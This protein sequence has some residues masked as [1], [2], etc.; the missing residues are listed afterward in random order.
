ML[1]Q[2][3]KFVEVHTNWCA[4]YLI[5][6]IFPYPSTSKFLFLYSCHITFQCVKCITYFW[7]FY[8]KYPP[9]SSFWDSMALTWQ[10]LSFVSIIFQLESLYRDGFLNKFNGNILLVSAYLHRT[11]EDSRV[12]RS[13]RVSEVEWRSEDEVYL[14]CGEGHNEIFE[15]P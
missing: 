14:V 9:I 5:W 13:R 15:K 4:I 6:G 3:N 2:Q 11:N 1:C 12:H 10:Y 7:S 8:S